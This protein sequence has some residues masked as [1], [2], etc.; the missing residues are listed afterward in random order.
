VDE[1]KRIPLASQLFS[2][3]TSQPQ[4][5][6]CV[7]TQCIT[8]RQQLGFTQEKICAGDS[9]SKILQSSESHCLIDD[10][11]INSFVRMRDEAEH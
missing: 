8:L 7:N 4:I 1:E 11:P 2:Y 10:E 3:V 9:S 6:E 5:Q